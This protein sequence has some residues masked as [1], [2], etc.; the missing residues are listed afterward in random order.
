MQRDRRIAKPACIRDASGYSVLMFDFSLDT[1]H[2]NKGKE[3]WRPAV[4]FEGQYEV[5]NHGRVRTVSRLMPGFVSGAGYHQVN[6]IHTEIK[7][8][9]RTKK[10]SVHLLV[11]EA[12][13]GPRPKGM[14]INH[15]DGNKRNNNAS[16]LEYMT[17]PDNL[18]HA[19]VT[20]LMRKGEDRPE[21]KLTNADVL[22][23]KRLLTHRKLFHREIAERFGVKRE[24]VSRIAL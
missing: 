3:E 7:K 13:L 8:G 12:F 24:V 21:T 17:Q 10:R 22:E 19:W 1:L 18:R 14:V 5:S 15:K 23:I 11:A 2:D 20:G 16:N 4:G 9:K 6:V